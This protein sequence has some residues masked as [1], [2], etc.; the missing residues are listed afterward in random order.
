MYQAVLR[1]RDAI[2][3]EYDATL[4]E[5]NKRKDEREQVLNRKFNFSCYYY[6]HPTS[7]NFK[8]F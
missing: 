2:Q 7:L 4:D 8:G 6:R 3:M 1:R 5:L